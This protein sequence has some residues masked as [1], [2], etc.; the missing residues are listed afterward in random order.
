M[1]YKEANPPIFT[2]ICISNHLIAD[3]SREKGK[4]QSQL[5]TS[6]FECLKYLRSV[7]KIYNENN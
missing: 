3:K 7:I 4:L 5:Q 1:D 6:Q 2:I